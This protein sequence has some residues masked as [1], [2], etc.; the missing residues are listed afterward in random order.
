MKLATRRGVGAA[1]RPR[2]PV[3]HVAELPA[4]GLPLGLA[5]GTAACM[6]CDWCQFRAAGIDPAAVALDHTK[7]TTHPTIARPE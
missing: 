1:R 5:A 6:V 7:A 2:L 4:E 3:E